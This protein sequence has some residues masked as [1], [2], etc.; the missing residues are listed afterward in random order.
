MLSV[1]SR[2][3]LRDSRASEHVTVLAV[4]SL[5][6]PGAGRKG[7][8]RE[9]EKCDHLMFLRKIRSE[10][11]RISSFRK[12]ILSESSS[13]LV[14]TSSDG[15]TSH[16]FFPCLAFSL[17]PFLSFLLCSYSLLLCHPPF[18]LASL[19]LRISPSGRERKREG[20]CTSVLGKVPNKAL[21]PSLSHTHTVRHG[22]GAQPETCSLWSPQAPAD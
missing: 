19:S 15:R 12:N 16:V 21:A 5:R 8:H 22:R 14:K 10:S 13:I 1:S 11:A 17:P 9:R 2:P 6:L 4:D 3:F 20:E 18:P 7:V